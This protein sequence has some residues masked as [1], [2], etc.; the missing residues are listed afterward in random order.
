MILENKLGLTSQVEL[1]KAEE[2]ISKKKAKKLYDSGRINEL[3]SGTFKGVSEIHDY[4]FSEIFDFAGEIRSVNIAKGNFRFA[5]VMYLEYSL[6]H[7]DQ[8]PQ[9]TFEGIIKKYVEMNIAHPFREGNGRSTRIW[10]D[11]IL[12]SE[13]QKVVDWNLIDKSDYLSAMERSPINDLEISYLISNA[14]TDKI[15]DRELYMK[16]IDVSYF[17]EGYSEYT[18]DDL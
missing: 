1:T 15:S 6:K 5:P 11:I 2:K 3:E 16:G 17:Y 4:L 9:A 10:L 8:M 7:I 18:I 14:L 12:K 13:I